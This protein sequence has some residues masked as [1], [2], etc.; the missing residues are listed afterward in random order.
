MRKYIIPTLKDSS[1]PNRLCPN[2]NSSTGRIHQRRRLPV[3]DTRVGQVT[4]LRMFCPSC[5]RTW[6]VQPDGLK[7]HFQRS[8]RMR[9]LNILFYALGLSFEAVATVMS[10]LGAPE[11]DTSVYRDLVDSMQTVKRLHKRGHRKVRVA[12]IDATYQRLA[13]PDN[14]CHQSTI[15]VVDFSDGHLLEVELIDEDDAQQVAALIK[16]LEARYGIELWVSDEHRSYDQAIAAERHL[17]CAAH[18]K[19]AKLRRIKELKEEVRSERM[20]QDLEALEE[21]LKAPPEDGQGLAR[22]IYQRQKR[23]RR[24]EK[25]KR[26]SPG[27]KLKALAREVYEKWERVWQATNNPTEAAIGLCLKIRSKLMRGFKIAE[28]IKGFAKMRGWMYEQGDRIE[29]GNLL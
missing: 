22:Q 18:F 9:A 11:S 4:K 26:A 13:Q 2:C 3:A 12:G 15:F 10:S 29:L 24:P 1:Q 6:T 21:L 19:R 28:H 25:G 7:A 17:L 8:Q 20:K 5:R 16:D 14:P 23:V 27:S